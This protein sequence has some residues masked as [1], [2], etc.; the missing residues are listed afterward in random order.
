MR[1]SSDSPQ[2]L[3]IFLV[4]AVRREIPEFKAAVAAVLE[5]A[6][7][8]VPDAGT[9]GYRE[10]TKSPYRMVEKALT[11]GPGK[12]EGKASGERTMGRV[13]SDDDYDTSS[14]SYDDVVVFE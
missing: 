4:L 7:I 5:Q 12:G 13:C 8:D 10:L 14:S 11:K 2:R 3:D 9:P 6:N 1:L